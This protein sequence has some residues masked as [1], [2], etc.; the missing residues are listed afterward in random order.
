MAVDMHAGKLDRR[1]RTRPGLAKPI[2]HSARP[3]VGEQARC[4]PGFQ[5]TEELPALFGAQAVADPRLGEFAGI[6]QR[7]HQQ[8]GQ[9]HDQQGDDQ[10]DAALPLHRAISAGCTSSIT[11]RNS[12][13]PWRWKPNSMPRGSAFA[14][15]SGNGQRCATVPSLAT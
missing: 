8:R 1:H 7:R 5:P 14:G 10:G 12:P 2:D 15:I 13:W 3:L 11:R 6:E 9:D 4:G